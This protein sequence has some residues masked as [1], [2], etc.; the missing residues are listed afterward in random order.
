MYTYHSYLNRK[1][2]PADMKYAV[3]SFNNPFPPQ[4]SSLMLL[5]G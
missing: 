5:T 4:T 1:E 2:I 3:A